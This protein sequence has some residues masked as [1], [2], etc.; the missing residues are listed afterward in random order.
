MVRK[1]Q[2]RNKESRLSPKTKM[3][4]GRI[5]EFIMVA[6]GAI[7]AAF[8]IEE[9]L[10][11]CLI[12]DGGVVGIGMI[13]NNLTGIKLGL[14]T[15]CMN[16]PFLIIGSRKM[17]AL[18]IC[19]SFF[20]MGIFSLFLEIFAPIANATNAY[21]LA[22]CFGGMFLGLGV[23]LVIRSGG[24]L[25]GTETVAMLLYKRFG[26]G[27]GQIVLIENIM[28]FSAAAFLFGLNRGM[29]SLLTY[30]VASKVID[31]VEV[32]LNTAKAAMI[33]TEDEEEICNLIYQKLGRTITI[34]EGEGLVSGKKAVL[35]CVITRSE[36]Y[37]LKQIIHE[38]D[39]S[40][41]VTLSDVSEIIGE[42]VKKSGDS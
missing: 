5:H 39:K 27:V 20:G 18:F 3:V 34:L 4:L 1:K 42:H 8:A 11:P 31:M 17:G 40:A 30:F 9:F 15:F 21:L 37:E 25:D 22:V 6:I 36:I 33:I 41:F 29:Y 19:K 7:I 32:G 35:Y 23:G 16:I 2:D 13:I 10:V 38:V 14:L 26:I 12:L 24:C 28:I